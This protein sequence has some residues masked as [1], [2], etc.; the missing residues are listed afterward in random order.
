M[1]KR[2]K[3][4]RWIERCLWVAAIIALGWVAFVYIESYVYQKY[5][6]YQLEQQTLADGTTAQAEGLAAQEF[7]LLA[8]LSVPR[9]DLSVM[10]REGVDN[11]TLRRAAGHIPGTA[12]PGRSGNVGIAGHRDTF[13]RPLKDIQENDVIEITT[14]EG[15]FRYRVEW[16]ARV[17]PDEI[18]VLD[19]TEHPSLTLVTCYPFNYVGN[20][21]ERFIVR[22]RET[23]DR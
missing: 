1:T 4:L 19:Q 17:K 7:P 5:A 21:P 3:R 18:H 8:R 10:V 12:A 13:F 23:T 22:A 11:K 14:R 16:T 2:K 15:E 9:L 20:A 6:S